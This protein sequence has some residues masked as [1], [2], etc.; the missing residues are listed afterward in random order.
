MA[1]KRARTEAAAQS[2]R[3]CDVAKL[4]F[5]EIERKDDTPMYKVVSEHQEVQLILTPE[6][7][8]VV[9]RGFDMCGDKEKR[10]FNSD[11]ANAKGTCLGLYVSL[12]EEQA[13]FLQEASEKI[14]VEMGFQDRELWTPLVP[15]SAKYE[16][17]AVGIK[18]TLHGGENNLT[19]LKIK[20]SNVMTAGKG[21]Q[22]LQEQAGVQKTWVNAFK[23]AEVKAVV[24]F[25]PWTMGAKAGVE[26]V[27]TQ[28]AL[29]LPERK[30]VD[31]LPDW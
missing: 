25:R 16:T 12:D 29:K 15:K 5:K 30:F 1:A 8:N 6:E 13:K 23:G 17:Y 10:P 27:A 7:P 11:D 4:T 14:R 24:K 31:V 26:L 19:A 3:E 21:W 9:L 18:V 2:F 20:Q 28:L 22:F